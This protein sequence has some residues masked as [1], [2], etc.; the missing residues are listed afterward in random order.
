MRLRIHPLPP[1]K[2]AALCTPHLG[3]GADLA[4]LYLLQLCVS[5]LLQALQLPGSCR[6]LPLAPLRL[7]EQLLVLVTQERSSY[8]QI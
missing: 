6:Q 2:E 7:L 1:R 5:V 3:L 8:R 4:V